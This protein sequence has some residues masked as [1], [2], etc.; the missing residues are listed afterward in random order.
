MLGALPRPSRPTA[1][2]RSGAASL[3]A[4]DGS[5]TATFPAFLNPPP[6]RPVA[7]APLIP[8]AVHSPWCHPLASAASGDGRA[9]EQIAGGR[10]C[11]RSKLISVRLRRLSSS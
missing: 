5:R 1:Q 4:G 10:E 6:I 8:H 9:V 2:G 7:L 3:G 11:I